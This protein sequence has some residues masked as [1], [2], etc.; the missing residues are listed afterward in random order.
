M[1][2]K[3]AWILQSPE[4]RSGAAE[5]A[6]QGLGLL[7]ASLYAA[8]QNNEELRNEVYKLKANLEEAVEVMA[9]LNAKIA[10][11][12]TLQKHGTGKNPNPTPNP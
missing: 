9:L 3:K 10:L 5:P 1:T 6:P 8:M 7:A 2:G 11:L 4:E 12:Q